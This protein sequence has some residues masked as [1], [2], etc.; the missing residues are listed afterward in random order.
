[1]DLELVPGND[2]CADCGQ[3]SNTCYVFFKKF[4]FVKFSSQI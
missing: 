1:M 4:L 3:K 2:K